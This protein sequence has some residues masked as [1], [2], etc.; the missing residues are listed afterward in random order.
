MPLSKEKKK[1]AK[2]MIS[3][4]IKEHDLEESKI[5]KVGFLDD[6]PSIGVITRIPTGLVGLDLLTNGGW[7]KGHIN[8]LFG[9][10]DAGKTTSILELISSYQKHYDDIAAYLPSEKSFDKEYAREKGIE[11][12]DL[13][14]C[15]AETAE[16]NLDFCIN[17]T[18]PEKSI[19]LLIIDTLQALAAAS[20][21]QDSKGKERSTEDKTMALNCSAT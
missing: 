11:L 2:K 8:Q 3:D 10:Q 18:D 19:G 12:D 6:N 17:C 7:V 16:Q 5:V 20:E 14:V 9:G 13:L 1:I 21:L 15:I 4:F